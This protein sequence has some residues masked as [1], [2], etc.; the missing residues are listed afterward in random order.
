[1]KRKI[2]LLNFLL[3]IF[4][5]SASAQN[6]QIYD[7]SVLPSE[8]SNNGDTLDISSVSDDSPG[9]D[10]VAEV[11]L[12]PNIPG[13]KIF[14][15]LQPDGKR[16]FRHDFT[17]TY[18]G[19]DFTIVARLK[20][21]NDPAFDRVMD[22]RWDNGNS[23]TRDELRLY[24][25]GRLKLEKAGVDN[26]PDV[27][28]TDW[29]IYRIQVTGDSATVFIDENDTPVLAGKTTSTTSSQSLRFGDG[30]G[31]AIGGLVDWFILDTTGA[32][33]PSQQA[34]PAELTGQGNDEMVEWNVYTASVLPNENIPA[35]EE[36]N[37]GGDPP[38]DTVIT[39]PDNSDNSLLKF[40]VSGADSKYMWKQNFSDS[41]NAVTVVMRV[42]G[43]PD[44]LDRTMEIDLQQGGFRER[45][46]IKNDSTFE[47][48]EA[49]VKGDLP[50]KPSGLA[51]LSLYKD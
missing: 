35:F 11:M 40:I 45:L 43:S 25:G 6:W 27:N 17:G 31:D 44:T 2:Y 20:G 7:G 51:Y 1:M 33:T 13:N 32:Y 34:L 42:K 19:T 3:L 21:V 9:A 48:K 50:I 16:T 36:S 29:H 28:F 18:S 24:Y 37:V 10:M 5:I 8:T 38:I 23:G 4:V 22:I 14:K 12:D 46:Y 41:P 30:S 15:Y 39:D 47:L 26:Y 49:G